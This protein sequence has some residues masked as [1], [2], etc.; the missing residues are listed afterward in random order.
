MWHGA[1]WTFIIWGLTHGLLLSLE[2]TGF[3]IWMEKRFRP[4]G[5][6]YFLLSIVLTFVIFRSSTLSQAFGLLGIMFGIGGRVVYWPEMLEYL[7]REYITMLIIAIAGSTTIFVN[8]LN[9]INSRTQYRLTGMRHV[10]HYGSSIVM[11]LGILMAL[12]FVT[13][14]LVSVTNNSFIYFKF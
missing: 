12:F 14:T 8:I 5:H 13:L 4:L 3:G 10:V 7:D 9:K 2:K 1:A 11:I 6:I